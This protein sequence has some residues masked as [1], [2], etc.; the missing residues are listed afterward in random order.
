MNSFISDTA[1]YIINNYSDLSKICIVV[2]NRRTGLFIKK[3]I[4]NKINRLCFAPQIIGIKDIF[5][6]NSIFSEA[7]EIHLIYLLYKVFKKHTGLKD[8]FDEF[9]YWGEIILKDF[10]YIDKYLAD[11]EKLF[12]NIKEIKEIDSLFDEYDEKEIEIIRKFW[13]NIDQERI[14]IHKRKFLDLWDSMFRIYKE[15][16]ELLEKDN[17]A[18]EGM[19]Y[20]DLIN[21]I[22]KI[23]FDKEKYIFI[24]F[25]AL[26]KCEL[27]LLKFFKKESKAEY[28]WDADKYYVNDHLQ[29]AGLFIRENINLFPPPKGVSISNEIDKNNADIEVISAPSEIAQTKLIPNILQEWQNK[30]DFN[31]EKTAI[32]LGDENLLIPLMYSIPHEISEYN[33]SMGYPI[34]NSQSFNFVLHLCNLIKNHNNNNNN[35]NN[36]NITSY[37]FKD[38]LNI[39]NHNFIK[40]S[41][42]KESLLCKEKIISEKIIM[43]DSKILAVNNLF[44][45]LFNTPTKEISL[46]SDYIIKVIDDIKSIISK[47]NKFK[48]EAEFLHRISLRLN[49]ISDAIIKNNVDIQNINTYFRLLYNSLGSLSIA[50]E[51]EPLKGLQ[52]LGFLE[53]RSL[54]FDRIIML[55]MNEGKFPKKTSPQSMIPYN[56]RKFYGLPCIEYQDSIFAYYFYRLLQRGKDIKII[57]SAQAQETT[58][59]A[60][61]FISQLEYELKNLRYSN[62]GYKIQSLSNPE[63]RVFKDDRILNEIYKHFGN[64]ISPSAINTYLNCPLMYY[65][66]YI[67]KIKEPENLEEKDDAAYFGLVFHES[68]RLIYYNFQNKTITEE[69]YKVISNEEFIKEKVEE[70]TDI[71]IGSKKSLTENKN[72]SILTD[73]VIK[74]IKILL[75]HDQ[76]NTPFNIISMEKEYC[77]DINLDLNSD[78]NKCKIKGTIDRV[79][80]KNDTYRV[81]DY[82]T[83]SVKRNFTEFETLFELNRKNDL[84]GITQVLLYAL[85]FDSENKSHVCPGLISITEL[86]TDPEHRLKKNKQEFNGL[87][88]EDYNHFLNLLKTKISEIYDVKMPILQTQE[89]KNCLYCDYKLICMR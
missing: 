53:T 66:K 4:S 33:V 62:S 80:I 40:E 25:N 89:L 68:M 77:F 56:I 72:D 54:D 5:I 48:F 37:Y 26:N 49:V 18:Y 28:F 19:I 22:Q 57:Y 87:D 79:D 1:N 6:S 11:A 3:E 86:L 63:I 58:G 71:I 50:F 31:P 16:K 83:G 60:S 7:E 45:I 32:I 9:F 75:K 59:E 29:E 46:V 51:G 10:D 15:F 12:S 38:V 85:L 81:L 14:S 52:I 20:R 41:F 74:Y 8:D 88:Q 82:K 84:N 27:E 21:N 44:S 61:R 64:G 24:G 2:P 55:S 43:C 30:H 42:A 73:I 78:N 35:N 23:N 39:L 13:E 76:I 34:K 17:I 47:S 36:N 69:T 65:F 67:E 70:A